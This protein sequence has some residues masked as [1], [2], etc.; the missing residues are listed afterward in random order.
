M[1]Y[2][3]VEKNE[4]TLAGLRTRI[5][6]IYEGVNPTAALFVEQIDEEQWARIAD[7]SDQEPAGVLSVHN[8][9]SESRAEGTELD[10]YIAAATNKSVADG[11]DTLTVP[12]PR[13][14]SR[15]TPTTSRPT[16]GM[17]SGSPSKRWR[18]SKSPQTCRAHDD[19]HRETTAPAHSRHRTSHRTSLYQIK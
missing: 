4:F 1:E 9:I 6:L 11:F 15:S 10:Y 2:R 19:G 3:I 7:L 12:A 14:S 8:A 5:P 16:V 17:S 13:W 18:T